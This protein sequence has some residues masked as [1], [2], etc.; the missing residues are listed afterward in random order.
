MK[1]VTPEV[2]AAGASIKQKIAEKAD[3]MVFN[4]TTKGYK[5]YNERSLGS[6]FIMT[7]CGVM[8]NYCAK[9][10]TT[11]QPMYHLGDVVTKVNDFLSTY[12]KKFALNGGGKE[13]DHVQMSEV[14]SSLTSH[15]YFYPK[16]IVHDDKD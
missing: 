8:R 9:N 13:E 10:T 6:F 7:L 3:T 12:V 1:V 5:A 2:Q 11:Q 4:S 14:C 15:V 16:N